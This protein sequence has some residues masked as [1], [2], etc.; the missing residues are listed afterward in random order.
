MFTSTVAGE[1][2]EFCCHGCRT[3]CET[4]YASGL[5]SFYS[6]S[7]RS[8]TL[9]PPPSVAKELDAYDL[10]EVQSD[11]VDSLGPQRTIQLLVEG[12]HCAACVW[13]IEKALKRQPG[14]IDAEVNLT[15]KRL[16]LR[17]DNDQIRLSQVMQILADIGYAAVPFDP[18]TAEGALAK[19]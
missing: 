6:Q 7:L 16:K 9:A 12:I 14:V 15:A 11:Y 8:D 2:R 10:D 3:V 19:R 17:W 1:Q 18:E 5:E 4:I 13:L